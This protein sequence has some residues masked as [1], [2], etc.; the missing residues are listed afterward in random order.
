MTREKG[1]RLRMVR[2]VVRDR[3]RGL[4]RGDRVLEHEQIGAFDFDHDGELVEV[5]DAGVELPAIY[6]V[7]RD[8][9]A[10]APRVVQEGVLNVGLSRGRG[11][12]FRY[13]GH[14]G[15][16]PRVRTPREVSTPSTR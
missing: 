7:D 2:E 10:I 8:R 14:Q 3:A 1:V 9:H 11:A 15:A 6:Q 5:L 16:S 12:W 13:L 4:D